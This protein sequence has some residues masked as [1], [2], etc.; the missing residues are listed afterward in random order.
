MA[1][2]GWACLVVGLL[3][4]AY[5]CGAALYGALSG[6]RQFVVSAR[7]GMYFLAGLMVLAFVLIETAFARSDFSFN[8]VQSYSSTD[9]PLFYKLTAMWSSQEGGLL[10]WA[11]LLSTFSSV[12][13]FATRHKHRQIAPYANAVLGTIAVFFLSLIVI[14]G[15]NPFTSVAHPAAEGQGLNPLLRHPAMMFHPPLLYLG[16]V[17]LT[18]PFAFMVGALVARRT[19]AD[20]IRSTRRFALIAWTFLG[21]GVLLGALWSYTELG[22]GGYWAWDPVENAAL[23]PW[24]TATAFLHSVMVQEKRGMLK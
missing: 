24:L 16:Y 5:S 14:G 18:I 3:V 19:N 10:L 17:G 1:D 11:T 8:L 22:W 7:R 4:A 20:W 13:L 6:K 15:E 12:V 23:M 21:T 9:T 2:L